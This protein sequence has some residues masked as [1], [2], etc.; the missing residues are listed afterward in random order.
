[1]KK[2]V[3]FVNRLFNRNSAEMNEYFIVYSNPLSISQMTKV[4][5]TMITKFS[6]NCRPNNISASPNSAA[7]RLHFNTA[8]MSGEAL[9]TVGEKTLEGTSPANPVKSVSLN[10]SQIWPSQ[11]QL[12][13]KEEAK[14]KLIEVLMGQVA[15]LT[16][17][18]KIE[19]GDDVITEINRL[20]RIIN[21]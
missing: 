1:M 16:I 6:P 3:A 18:S 8:C 7:V 14:S 5:N 2:L 4:V 21:E 10:G 9:K 19:L 17:M 20:N 12:T 11:E 15:D 13:A